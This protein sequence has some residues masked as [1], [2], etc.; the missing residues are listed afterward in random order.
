MGCVDRVASKIRQHGACDGDESQDD[1]G[2]SSGNRREQPVQ[3]FAADVP[4]CDTDSDWQDWRSAYLCFGGQR[5]QSMG[6]SLV[7]SQSID[8][9]VDVGILLVCCGS[10]QEL[11]L[12]PMQHVF[13]LTMGV[14]LF[15]LAMSMHEDA[16]R[17]RCWSVTITCTAIS[18]RRWSESRLRGR[19]RAWTEAC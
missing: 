18:G 16:C 15:K 17:W 11:C 8:P 13:T 9:T 19:V 3:F 12:T 7:C 4:H 6:R 2:D 14:Q 5:A 1:S 10:Y